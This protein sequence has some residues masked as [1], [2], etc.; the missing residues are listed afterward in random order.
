MLVR[1][2]TDEGT[3][4]ATPWTR[5]QSPSTSFHRF[6]SSGAVPLKDSRITILLRATAEPV[7]NV[8]NNSAATTHA[9]NDRMVL[10]MSLPHDDVGSSTI[11]LRRDS[12]RWR[13]RATASG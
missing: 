2:E 3:I 9:V 12:K 8:D 13:G 6:G 11:P 7:V 1:S 4:L 5:R 10:D